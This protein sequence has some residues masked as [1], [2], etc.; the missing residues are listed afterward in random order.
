M[1]KG[2]NAWNR[3]DKNSKG[4][5][6]SSA[7]PDENYSFPFPK[8]GLILRQTMRDLPR[9]DQPHHKTDSH[10]FDHVWMTAEEVKTFTPAKPE[11]GLKYEIPEKIVR[12]LVKFHLI[13]QVKGESPKWEES[14]ILNASINAIVT[15]VA[16]VESGTPR[17]RIR[18]KGNAKCVCPPTGQ[19]NPYTKNRI[20]TE[21]GI[22]VVIR[23]WLTYDT[24]TKTFTDFEL[25]ACGERW[26]T[27]TY[28]FRARDLERS[29]IG[30]AFEK[31]E[32]KPE[33]LIRPAFARQGYFDRGP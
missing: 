24:K 13:D 4:E 27:A 7:E 25:L 8:G 26:G 22:D 29:P 9:P 15:Q 31:L 19:V 11:P 32:P 21:R 10:N 33:N 3:G 6:K 28:S 12:R 17:I 14:Q 20:T 16:D 30:F 2:I 5:C 18:L 23:G 1:Q